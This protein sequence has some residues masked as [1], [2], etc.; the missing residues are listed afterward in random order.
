METK[1]QFLK[2]REFAI[3]VSASPSKI[4]EG[5]SDGS[6]PSVRIAGLLRIPAAFAD[7]L[8]KRALAPETDEAGR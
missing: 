6:I 5:I 1:K 8:A 3:R 2:V 7:E 4:Y